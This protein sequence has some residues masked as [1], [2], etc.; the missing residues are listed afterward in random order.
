VREKA[1]IILQ[2]RQTDRQ[3]FTVLDFVILVV[4]ETVLNWTWT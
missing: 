4:Q 3:K 2:G 1:R